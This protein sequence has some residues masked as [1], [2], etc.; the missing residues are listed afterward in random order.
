MGNCGHI[1]CTKCVEKGMMATYCYVCKKPIT[2]I[3]INSRMKDDVKNFFLDPRE[4]M[5]QSLKDLNKVHEFQNKNLRRLNTNR[6]EKLKQ[7]NRLAEEYKKARSKNS[8]LEKELNE[9]KQVNSTMASLNQ[10]HT[11]TRS[12]SSLRNFSNSTVANETLLS[13]STKTPMNMT[14]TSDPC[15]VHVDYRIRSMTEPI[16]PYKV[17]KFSRRDLFTQKSTKD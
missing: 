14:A 2:L 12:D 4:L 11:T 13:N 7:M 16:E 17:K 10:S 1:C 6:E 8:E 15:E 5:K 3:E 9:T